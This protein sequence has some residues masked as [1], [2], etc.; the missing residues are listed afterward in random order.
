MSAEEVVES[1][2][3]QIKE[4]DVMTSEPKSESQ[5]KTRNVLF[6]DHHGGFV[7]R[8]GSTWVVIH[9]TPYGQNTSLHSRY[10]QSV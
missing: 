10:P 4:V 7:S 5:K 1:N 2:D 9:V 8:T 3:E 6:H